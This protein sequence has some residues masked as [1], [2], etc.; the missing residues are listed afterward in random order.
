[1]VEGFGVCVCVYIYIYI[2]MKFHSNWYRQHGLRKLYSKYQSIEFW[3][4][5]QI[6]SSCC[7][8][9]TDI[10]DPLYPPL[11]IIHCSQQVLRV[12]SHIGIELLDVGSKWPSNLC[13]SMWRGSLWVRPY[14]SSSVPHVWFY[15]TWIVFMMGGRRPYS[16]CFVGH[17]SI[18]LAA[19]LC[20]CHQAFSPYV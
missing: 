4:L 11:P 3:N 14:F 16:C 13:S 6:S 5:F 12:T 18:L 1:M 9:S 19:F 7:A 15:L 2:Y 20:S 17:C 8:I 10:A